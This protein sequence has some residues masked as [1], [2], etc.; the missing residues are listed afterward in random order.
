MDPD[1]T[2]VKRNFRVDI[3]KTH[4]HTEIKPWS[5]YWAISVLPK[6]NNSL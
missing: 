3:K 4:D 2:T 6:E 5:F 1:F